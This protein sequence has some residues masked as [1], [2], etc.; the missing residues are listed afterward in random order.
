MSKLEETIDNLQE[1]AE[2]AELIEDEDLFK[3]LDTSAYYLRET[4]RLLENAIPYIETSVMQ[5]HN[6]KLLNDIRSIL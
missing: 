4:K 6:Q 3:L 2:T 5:N 1:R